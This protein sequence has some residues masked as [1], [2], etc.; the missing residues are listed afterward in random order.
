MDFRHRRKKV[1]NVTEITD[2]LRSWRRLDFFGGNALMADYLKNLAA[3]R[4]L[5]TVINIRYDHIVIN[6][7]I[8]FF[9]LFSDNLHNLYLLHHKRV[10]KI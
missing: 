6:H 2:L 8:I 10:K 7:S 1:K 4:F 9:L 3:F 5:G